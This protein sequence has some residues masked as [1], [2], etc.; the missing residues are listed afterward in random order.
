ME[1]VRPES[2]HTPAGTQESFGSLLRRYRLAAGL[3]QEALAERAG[4]SV[5]GLSALESGKRQAP[6]R[7]TVTLLATALGLSSE[8][9]ARLHAAVVRVRMPASTAPTS[10]EQD[11]QPV[12]AAHAELP[13][14]PTSLIG[15]EHDVAAVLALLQRDD[16]RLLTLTGPGGVGKTRLALQVA[17]RLQEHFADGVVFVSLAPLSEPNPVLATVARALGVIEQGNQPLQGRLVTFLR[18]KH[19]LLVLD[20]FEHVAAAASQLAPLLAACAGLR[21]IVTSRAPLRLQGERVFAVPPLALPDLR[22]LPPVEALGQV[23]A[24]AL[25]VE[26]A[27]A[28]R[29]D[30]TLTEATAAAVAGICVRL[31]GLPL[32]IEL[33]AARVVVL[34]PAALLARLAQPL[35]VLTGGPQD[36]PARQQTLRATIAWSYSLLSPDEQ[37]LFRC[38]SVFAGGAT[39]EAV[40]AVYKGSEAPNDSTAGFTMLDGVSRLVHLHLLRMGPAGQ[41]Y[42]AGEPR[43]TML[44]TLR[45]YGRE[46]LGATGD[47]E[48]VRRWHASYFLTLAEEAFSHLLHHEQ[49][50][51]LDRLEEELDNLRS[52]LAWCMARGQEGDRDA[53]ERGLLAAG[54]LTH[55]WQI[56]GH[57]LE[58]TGWLE[59]LLALPAAQGRTRGRVAALWCLAVIRTDL[60]GN[61]GAAEAVGEESVAIARELGDPWDLALALMCWGAMEA[62]YPRPGTTD[63]ALGHAYLEEAATLLQ[64][65]DAPDRVSALACTLVFLGYA[66]FLEGDQG[67]AELQLTRGIELAKATGDRWYVAIG[68]MFLGQLAT[69]GGDLARARTVLE[70]SLAHHSALGSAFHSGWVLTWLGDVLQGMG[71]PVMARTYYACALHTLHAIGHAQPSHWALCGLAELVGEHPYALTLIGVSSSLAQVVGAQP[72]PPVL[73]RLE[74]VRAIAAQVLSAEAQA[75]AWASGQT[76]PLEQVIAEALADAGLAGQKVD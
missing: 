74:Q 16:V 42:P 34:P 10:D 32:A 37:A 38:L 70:Q 68:L 59:R 20:N 62:T 13:I 51:W 55:F 65:S 35:Q 23:P 41:G 46:Q 29:A 4:L 9:A 19:L 63:L 73:A 22:Y 47:L 3:T 76:M 1:T 53:V 57:L 6:Y 45:E 7:H 56:R 33:A 26:R 27:Q 71:D 17:T 49:I 30:F 52:A 11:A 28:M 66:L 24:V 60:L 44:E 25:F 15:R 54:Y 36:L 67:E 14:P 43:F 12:T 48:A 40:E 69:A 75:A 61:A 64:A 58:A 50:E 5:P 8:E 31:D 2:L 21:L 18:H 72:S 39:L